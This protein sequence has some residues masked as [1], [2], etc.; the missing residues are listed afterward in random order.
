[1]HGELKML[2]ELAIRHAHAL[3]QPSQHAMLAPM[4]GEVQGSSGTGPVRSHTAGVQQRRF[5]AVQPRQHPT[6]AAF[7][8]GEP[9]R[10]VYGHTI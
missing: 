7:R 3:G 5:G 10:Y 9:G 4:R 2:R 8:G 1:V 6:I